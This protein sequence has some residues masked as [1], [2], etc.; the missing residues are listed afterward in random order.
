MT[1][2]K[3][4]RHRGIMEQTN[5][6]FDLA[7]TAEERAIHDLLRQGRAQAITVRE[8]A[9]RT[10]LG[11]RHIRDAVRSLIMQHGILVASAVDDPAGFFVAETPEE[12]IPATPSP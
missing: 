10:G 9:A 12:I 11:D 4:R 2:R 6:Q 5:L 1:P 7:L 8:L 3:R